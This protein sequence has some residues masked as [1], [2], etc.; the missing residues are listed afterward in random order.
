MSKQQNLNIQKEKGSG[1][2]SKFIVFVLLLILTGCTPPLG[3]GTEAF[4]VPLSGPDEAPGGATKYSE[5]GTVATLSPSTVLFPVGQD[6]VSISITVTAPFVFNTIYLCKSPCAT[7]D[8][9]VNVDVFGGNLASNYVRASQGITKQLSLQRSH[10]NSGNNF[11]AINVCNGV[12][13]CGNTKK[14]VRLKFT[15]TFETTPRNLMCSPKTTCASG[16]AEVLQLS[17]IS[18]AHAALPGKTYPQ[19]I[20]CKAEGDTISAGTGTP[21]VY[22]SAD[23]DAQL[24]SAAAEGY[25]IV[26]K[27]GASKSKITCAV[28]QQVCPEA[29]V[30]S[31]SSL[32]NAHGAACGVYSNN[33]CC[34]LKDKCFDVTC[35][36]GQKCNSVDG[37]C[38]QCLNNPDCASGKKCDTASHTCVDLCTGVSCPIGQKCNPADGTCFTP[39]ECSGKND[40]ASC[41]GGKGSC[42]NQRCTTSIATSTSV[43]VYAAVTQLAAV[44]A[45]T[46]VVDSATGFAAGDEIMIHQSSAPTDAQVGRYEFNKIAS[47]QGTVIV[48]QTPL[49]KAYVTTGDD[50]AQIVRVEQYEDIIVKSGGVLTA[51]AWTGNNKAGILLLKARTV[52]VDSGGKIEMNTK[53]YRASEGPGKG[54]E[55]LYCGPYNGDWGTAQAASSGGGGGYGVAGTNGGQGG[56]SSGGSS[57]V[58]YGSQYGLINNINFGSGGGN[59]GGCRLR[60]GGSRGTSGCAAA[61]DVNW[62]GG[63]GGLGGG[64]I[65]L[66]S[67]AI[68]VAGTIEAKGSDGSARILGS[69]PDQCQSLGAG[70]GGSGGSIL[71]VT[72]KENVVSGA[73]QISGGVGGAGKYSTGGIG[74]AGRSFTNIIDLCAGISCSQKCKPETGACVQ[75][76]ADADC[77][78]GKKC[79]TVTNTCYVDQCAGKTCPTGQVCN[80]VDGTCV[81]CSAASIARVILHDR[82]NPTDGVASGKITLLN[83][84]VVTASTS[85]GALPND[86]SPGQV[87]LSVQPPLATSIKVELTP[88]LGT[89]NVGLQD[90]QI[91]ASVSGKEVK[92]TGLGCTAG[93]EYGGSYVCANALDGNTSTEWAT[94]GN[95][96]PYIIIT[97]C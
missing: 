97:I 22:L 15:A 83:N 37:T 78:A 73:L 56:Q 31:L 35:P 79:N 28:S 23:T 88:T 32:T 13:D 18:N 65:M 68:T 61:A 84:N 67:N 77:E 66:M 64:I 70:G 7:V 80:P 59:G 1:G 53:G 69:V 95:S 34:N 46:I 39:S 96:N 42:I 10:L 94:K 8:N 72:R 25:G 86:G 21:F 44:G 92:L 71:F 12:I 43:G 89:Q 4:T 17:D 75:C 45:T 63:A 91:F 9:W 16:E 48:L 57:G 36:P 33:V 30:L 90:A 55:G 5:P 51:P 27:M 3:K 26:A 20:C 38:V 85:F 58:V 6:Q 24:S 19:K 14:W 50:H 54:G 74:G 40:G 11:L 93:S 62:G 82:V 47:V 41:L 2:M 76:L 52:N 49:Q 29:C 81:V 87:L 60:A